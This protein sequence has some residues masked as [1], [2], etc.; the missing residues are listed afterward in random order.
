MQKLTKKKN[1][2][3]LYLNAKQQIFLSSVAKRKTLIA[4]RGFGKTSVMGCSTYQK[5]QL[6]PGG[7]I[8]FAALTY[9]QIL[10][11]TLPAIEQMWGAIGL[12]EYNGPDD[13]GHYVV[14]RRPPHYFHKPIAPPRKYM[15]VITFFNGFTIECLSLD[16]MDLARGGS[17]DGG[18]IDE[19]ALVPRERFAKILSPSLRG[20]RH[21]FNHP[22]HHSVSLY[23]SM[24][25]KP[26][27]Y[28]TLEMEQ[29]ALEDPKNYFYLEATAWDNIDILG[30]EAIAQM[31]KDMTYHEAQIELHNRRLIKV[32]SAFYHAFDA[33][34]HGYT[35]KYNYDDGERGIEAKGPD[36]IHPN[37]LIDTTWD[38]GGWF[39]GCIAFQ[40]KKNVERAV[41]KFFIKEDN[42]L[43]DLVKQFTTHFRRH[44][45]KYI[46]I[47]GEPRGHDRRPDGG[48]MYDQIKGYFEKEGWTCEICV[49]P[50]RTEE[51]Q[52]RYEMMN[53]ILAEDDPNM[54]KL[55]VN[56]DYCKDVMIAMQTTQVKDD[57]KKNKSAER[58]REFP[59]EH[60]PHFTDMIDY[61]FLQK[62]GWRFTRR[63]NSGPFSIDFL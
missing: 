22:L 55:R 38:F 59:Q 32:E 63:R 37:E 1:K 44:Q 41:R 13:P 40:E 43:Q 52:I 2:T 9:N 7:K 47:W 15:N 27:G 56:Q 14:G 54:V 42:K 31:E 26:S 12:K 62:H 45:F 4:G 48:S 28:W 51:H 36:D 5:A 39:S 20:N 53:N 57:F 33:E 19:A 60:A 34:I 25:W 17:Y 49:A 58:N 46:R 16:R 24:P 3:P 50:Q 8:F 21:I 6:F 30:A 10:T 61:Y 35:P 29:K 11:K 23:T 18:E